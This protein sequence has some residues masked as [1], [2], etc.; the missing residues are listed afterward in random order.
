MSKDDTCDMCGAN[1]YHGYD[2]CQAISLARI[3]RALEYLVK[4]PK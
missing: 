2:E 3:A 1:E 4:E